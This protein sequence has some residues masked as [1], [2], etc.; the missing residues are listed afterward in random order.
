MSEKEKQSRDPRCVCAWCTSADGPLLGKPCNECD[1]ILKEYGR[2]KIHP[3]VA[4]AVKVYEPLADALQT[5]VDEQNGPP[6]FR[7]E[8]RW[9][10]AMEKSRAALKLYP[11]KSE[12]EQ[13]TCGCCRR[14]NDPTCHVKYARDDLDITWCDEW[15]RMAEREAAK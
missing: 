14:I 5:L 6:L 10:E 2:F 13:P 8:K 7:H 15:E 12:E 4:C 9:K 11:A 3:D 1:V